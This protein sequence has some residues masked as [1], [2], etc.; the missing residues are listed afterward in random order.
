MGW[1]FERNFL[2]VLA[3]KFTLI[4]SALYFFLYEQH[5]IFNHALIE[6]QLTLPWTSE[7]ST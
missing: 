4:A 5:T 1:V 2:P 6:F 7:T 3:M